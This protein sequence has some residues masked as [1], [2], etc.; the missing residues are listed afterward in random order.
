MK[1]K[2]TELTFERWQWK[3]ATLKKIPGNCH[4]KKGIFS[5][6]RSGNTL[7]SPRNRGKL[8]WRKETLRNRVRIEIRRLG[9]ARS[10]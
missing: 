10:Y 6:F 5:N 3:G 7:I 1:R 2:T 9:K 8:L 4:W